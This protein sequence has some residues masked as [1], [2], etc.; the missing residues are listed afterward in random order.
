MLKTRTRAVGSLRVSR[1]TRR[2]TASSYRGRG[3]EGKVE[4]LRKTAYPEEE[5][6]NFEKI[7]VNSRR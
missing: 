2:T 3:G 5:A 7:R 1:A 4:L 6:E